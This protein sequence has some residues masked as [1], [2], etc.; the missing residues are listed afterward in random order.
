MY[1]DHDGHFRGVENGV[2]F[3]DDDEFLRMRWWET[4]IRPPVRDADGALGGSL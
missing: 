2:D 1:Y 3:Q 4:V